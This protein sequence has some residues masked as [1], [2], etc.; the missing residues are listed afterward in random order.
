MRKIVSKKKRENK[1][2]INQ[3]IVGGILVLIM[4]ASV[5]GYAF[6]GKNSDNNSKVKY[7][8]F[9]FTK[10]NDLWYLGD[11]FM[12]K[13]NP[14]E[15]ENFS[16]ENSLNLIDSYKGEPLY[17]YSEDTS[18]ESEIYRNVNNIAQR[19][20]YACLN[21]SIGLNCASSWPVKTCEDNFILIRE[22]EFKI[23]QKDNCLFIQGPKENLTKISD[24]VLFK[25]IGLK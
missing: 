4:F 18:A 21:E 24:E 25:I 2:R 10:Q 3:I 9:E 15:T 20:Q 17:I 8:K 1:E 12:F 14:F 23:E 11:N 16:F 13:Y 7:N 19:I 22:G 6:Q 5:V